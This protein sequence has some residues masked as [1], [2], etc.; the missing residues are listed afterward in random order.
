MRRGAWPHHF[1]V[2]RLLSTG[3]MRPVV[4]RLCIPRR[5]LVEIECLGCVCQGVETEFSCCL[6]NGSADLNETA[7]K[8]ENKRGRALLSASDLVDPVS[9]KSPP[10]LCS[11][12]ALSWRCQ[13][14]CHA[15][16][17]PHARVH[18]G[19]Q[20]VLPNHSPLASKH[21]MHP[22]DMSAVLL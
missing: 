4:A 3:C 1:W 2:V 7:Q 10:A 11:I 12:L 15:F 19:R 9:G 13:S 16:I 17:F 14:L 22:N 8:S 21:V 20:S 6:I 18:V 5:S